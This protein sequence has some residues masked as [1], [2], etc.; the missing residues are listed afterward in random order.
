MGGEPL[1]GVRFVVSLR[2]RILR[3]WQ[4]RRFPSIPPSHHIVRICKPKYVQN[5]EI[6]PQAFEPIKD[7]DYL[8]VHWLEYLN[9][10][11]DLAAGF[12]NLRAFLTVSRF[13]DLKPQKTGRLAALLAG[14]FAAPPAV[15]VRFKCK[16]VAR[17][18]PC[19]S[20]G[21][22][23]QNTES[24]FDPHAGVYTLPW[25]GAELLAVQQYLLSKVIYHEPAK[26]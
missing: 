16:H 21:R 15:G 24:G 26:K 19:L 13:N 11:K 25:K 22:G 6:T 14:G 1:R 4:L 20:D 3:C 8:S 23:H 2:E 12:D 17:E 10:D 18:Q 5:G 9:G 7:E